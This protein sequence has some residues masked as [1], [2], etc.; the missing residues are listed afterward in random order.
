MS[1]DHIDEMYKAGMVIGSHG[2]SHRIMSRLSD[3]E[4]KKE[5]DDSFDLLKK[6]T[7]YKTFCYPYGGFSTFHSEIENYLNK[8]SVLFSVNVESRDISLD[9]LKN[10]KQSLPRYD[11]N[12]F[13]YGQIAI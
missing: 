2:V 13:K 6:Y 1:L 8:K 11:C 10:R 4:F 3:F 5:I 7:D 12:E 9:D